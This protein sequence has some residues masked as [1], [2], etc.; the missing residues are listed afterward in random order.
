MGSDTIAIA[1]TQCEHCIKRLYGTEF[2][3]QEI[4]VHF[5]FNLSG[6]RVSTAIINK[7][8]LMLSVLV[9]ITLFYLGYIYYKIVTIQT[10]LAILSLLHTKMCQSHLFT[11]MAY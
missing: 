8:H 5:S 6:V 3:N 9:S 7:H 1:T 2:S 10:I 4:F 11:L